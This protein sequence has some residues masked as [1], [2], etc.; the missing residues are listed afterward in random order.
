MIKIGGVDYDKDSDDVKEGR[1]AHVVALGHRSHQNK[2]MDDKKLA[3]RHSMQRM[4]IR[5]EEENISA[6][7]IYRQEQRKLVEQFDSEEAASKITEF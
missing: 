4:K 6:G 2:T 3:I 5:A 7:E 1:I